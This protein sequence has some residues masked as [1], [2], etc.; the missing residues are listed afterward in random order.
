MNVPARVERRGAI[1]E[2]TLDRPPVNAINNEVTD[3][4]YRAFSTLRDD[5][6]LRVGILTGAGAKIFSAG[7]DLKEVARASSGV[8][9]ND[10]AMLRPGGFAGLTE[11][12]D[13]NKPVIAAVNG[14]AVGG[15]F[16]LVLACDIVVAVEHA[17]F[18]F[19]EMQR[20]FLSDAG[21]AQRLPRRIPYNVAMEM[22]LTGRRM[23]A[24]EAAHWGLVNAVVPAAQLMDKAREYATTIVE[25]APL[26]VES[27]MEA[28]PELMA[29]SERAAFDRLKRGRSRLPAYERML[30]SE[31]FL[32]G[33][34][35]FAEKR[36][37]VWKGR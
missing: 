23:D 21:A 3:S 16:E 33:P 2:V 24:A 27:L 4:I 5:P 31:D 1:L 15:G 8:E 36:K 28:V 9:V 19:P 26:A 10:A 13:L 17:Q 34:R 25:G 11:F 18:F 22:M 6:G 32:E 14:T 30:A 29:M 7:W 37:P 35:A 20:G 12:W